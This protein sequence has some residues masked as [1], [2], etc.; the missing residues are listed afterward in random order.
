MIET[1]NHVAQGWWSLSV[2]MFWQVG[3]LIVAIV[4]VDVL[5]RKHIW[6]QIRYALWLMVLVKL[7][8]PPGLH[9]PSS[10]TSGVQPLAQKLAVPAPVVPNGYEGSELYRILSTPAPFV[11][12]DRTLLNASGQNEVAPSI[13]IVK[14][15]SHRPAPPGLLASLNWQVYVMG[16]WMTGTATF[17]LWLVVRLRRLRQGLPHSRHRLPASFYEQLGMC[18]KRVGLRS[19]PNVVMTNRVVVPAVM[20]AW[21]PVLLMPT[22][23]LSQLSRKDTMHMLLH[24]LSH[25]KRGDLW[26]HSAYLVL[27]ITYWYNPLL[28]LVNR[29]MHHLRELC[30]DASVAGLLKEHT[31]EYRNTLLDVA[32]R[33]LSRPTE[34]SL[35]LLGLFEDSNH[36]AARLNWLKKDTHRFSKTRT[37]LIVLLVGIMLACVLPMAQADDTPSI[38]N[39]E[40][41]ETPPSEYAELI[42]EIEAL[43]QRVIKKEKKEAQPAEVEVTVTEQISTG[44]AEDTKLTELEKAT[45]LQQMEFLTQQQHALTK[46]LDQLKAALGHPETA[47]TQQSGLKQHFQTQLG[48]L[49]KAK[50]K[51]HD[52]KQHMAENEKLRELSLHLNHMTNEFEPWVDVNDVQ[53]RVKKYAAKLPKEVIPHIQQWA[54]SDQMKSWQADMKT[55]EK[56]MEAWGKTLAKVTEGKI[57]SFKPGDAPPNLS[58]PNMPPMP[59]MPTMPSVPVPSVQAVDVFVS[60][61]AP[62]PHPNVAHPQMHVEAHVAPSEVAAPIVGVIDE[63]TL[64]VPEGQH[65]SAPLETK[66]GNITIVDKNGHPHELLA[67]PVMP[68]PHAGVPHQVQVE[69]HV[70]T[71]NFVRIVEGDIRNTTGKL[72]RI[73]KNMVLSFPE[74]KCQSVSLANRVGDITVMGTEGNECSVEI[75]IAAQGKDASAVKD[76]ADQVHVTTDEQDQVLTIT[77][78]TP[79]NSKEAQVTVAF[80]LRIP[81]ALNLDLT[82]QVGNITVHNM[83]SQVNCHANVGNIRAQAIVKALNVNTNVGEIYLVVTDDT[84]AQI[85]ALSNLGK[86]QS[87]QAFT[88]SPGNNT[89][90]KGALSLGSGKSPVNL[91]VNVGSIHVGSQADMDKAGSLKMKSKTTSKTVNF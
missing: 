13:Q 78:N 34:P 26:V 46:Q 2:S 35:G 43:K 4:C 55:W 28:W 7:I 70:V 29:R 41:K 8:L 56:S 14:T 68:Q 47:K 63:L 79:E 21:R 45:L 10:V 52:M 54:S 30:C 42:K 89:G 81:R 90:A 38:V 74:S 20:G 49:D 77:P 72:T 60:P 66:V 3:L 64:S 51:L 23:F 86:I 31:M 85:S 57:R 87:K 37:L 75:K 62:Q 65:Q 76:L 73:S 12:A 58:A 18:A 71:P 16:F 44:V 83:Q 17:G 36:L 53:V 80:V 69:T 22:G 84:D 11:D 88:L 67:H 24:E 82:T 91:R 5:L 59:K 39:G 27:Q 32:R 48:H 25:I 15:V 61:S 1:L 33:Y 19:V 50:A 6:P 9:S 40:T